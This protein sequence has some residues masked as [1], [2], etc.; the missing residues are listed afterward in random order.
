MKNLYKLLFLLAAVALGS[1]C[2]DDKTENPYPAPTVTV[3]TGMATVDEN[4]VTL[5]GSYLYEGTDAVSVGFR[6]A[7][8]ET[9]LLTADIIPAEPIGNKAFLLKIP[10]VPNGNYYYQGVLR[11]GEQTFVGKTGF[12]KVDFSTTPEVTTEQ[13]DISDDKITLKGSYKF[14]SRKIPIQ[15]GF[16]YADTRKGLDN[17]EFKPAQDNGDNSFSLEVD[18]GDYFYQA[19]AIVQGNQ[20]KGDVRNVQRIKDL[21]AEGAANCFIVSEAGRYSFE[22][23]R[24]DNTPVTGTKAEWVWATAKQ[25]LSDITYENGRIEF[26]ATGDSGNET[27][28]L[29]DADNRIQWSWHIWVTEKPLDQTYNN[30][31]MLD[32]NI[33]ATATDAN[34]P[35]SLGCYFQWGRKDPFVGANVVQ[36][37]DLYETKA[38]NF[39]EST[40]HTWTA[41]YVYND[42][43]VKGFVFESKEMDE[44]TSIAN[45]CTHYGVYAQ[46]GWSEGYGT[47]SNYW[48]GD[49]GS[50]GKYDPCPVGY[51]VPTKDE[52]VNYIYNLTN[53]NQAQASSP[54]TGFGKI[55]GYNNDT[56]NFPGSGLRA[57]SALLRYPGRV[58]LLWSS[59]LKDDKTAY[60]FYDFRND[61]DADP[62]CQGMAIRCIK[63]KE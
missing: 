55:I 27:V 33:G 48:G 40:D 62:I 59:N 37:D 12:F 42:N 18:A 47:I 2:E 56:Y 43:L 21:T 45:P 60:R 15:L 58:I 23:K 10:Y 13:A 25:I 7:P 4:E 49:S 22:T 52:L 63:I 26:K 5:E 39:T 17:A 46:G 11:L 9:E 28:A 6:Y 50:K 34:L 3:K 32:R 41:P 1:A 19:V 44:A 51:R 57:W 38:F 16:F 20:F 36:G 53:D 8:T 29:L 14:N 54:K 30:M 31:T 35:A 61:N 24:P